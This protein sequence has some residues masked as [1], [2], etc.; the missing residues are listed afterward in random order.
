MLCVIFNR[1]FNAQSLQP[2]NR[3]IMTLSP[4]Q[5]IKRLTGNGFEAFICGGYVRD[6]LLGK[7]LTDSDQDIATNARPDELLRLFGGA[8]AVLA[9]DSFP[10]VYVGRTE[11]ATY[12]G[13][14]FF[15]SRGQGARAVVE[16]AASLTDDLARRDLTIN[17]M[18]YNPLSGELIDPF[19]GRRDLAGRVIRFVAD[20]DARIME[21]PLRILRACRFAAL[22][23]GGFDEA[24][25]RALCRHAGLINKIN[26]DTHKPLVPPER[27]SQEIKKAMKVPRASGFFR[28][29][30]DIGVLGMVLPSLEACYE[31]PHGGHHTEDVFEHSMLCGDLISPRFPLL[32]LAGYLHDV[33]KP[34]SVAYGGD[35]NI[36]NFIGHEKTGAEIL[37][38]E[39]AGLRFSIPE[40]ERIAALAA[41]HMK[42]L[43]HAKPKTI[44]KLVKKWNDLGLTYQ[45]YIRLEI[46]DRKANL[47]YPSHDFADIR[48]NFVEPVRE[49]M[50]DNPPLGV[51]DLALKGQELIDVFGLRPG[52]LVGRL[53]RELLDHVLEYPAHNQPDHL[54]AL[55]EALLESGKD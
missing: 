36:A 27:I 26:P 54:L 31:H 14:V 43:S 37:R 20:P 41:D 11:V 46:A 6:M 38:E 23:G 53:Q 34:L 25:R 48:H 16:H 22:L 18:A 21:D 32:K 4:K 33:G 44:R 9:G 24:S 17:A 3:A 39:L 28:A 12:R 5:I 19:M 51:K 15:Q 52:P 10:V 40:T 8:G 45:D 55:A 50:A 2:S 1:T 7:D 47:S 42:R 29:M 13:K 49:A 35:G 30:H